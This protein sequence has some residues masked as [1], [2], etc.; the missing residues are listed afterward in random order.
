MLVFDYQN[1]IRDKINFANYYNTKFDF[2]IIGL[3]SVLSSNFLI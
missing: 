2:H 1:H 3:K